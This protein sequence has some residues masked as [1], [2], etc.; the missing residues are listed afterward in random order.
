[1]PVLA[2]FSYRENGN[3]AGG[4][5]QGTI[6]KQKFKLTFPRTIASE[7]EEPSSV[8]AVE[9]ALASGEHL[10][11][12][13][14]RRGEGAEVSRKCP[15]KH[16]RSTPAPSCLQ[17]GPKGIFQVGEDRIAPGGC[18]R[19]DSWCSTESSTGTCAAF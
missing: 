5:T 2:P 18:V 10:G 6:V 14:W 7:L 19:G 16:T 12:L 4:L 9:R 3:T 17:A 13:L 11:E 8:A 1:M 15:V